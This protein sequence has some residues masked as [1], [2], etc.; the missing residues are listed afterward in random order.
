MMSVKKAAIGCTMRI[1]ERVVRVSGGRLNVPVASSVRRAESYASVSAF[2]KN[3]IC[4]R[5]IISL[6][7][8]AILR[9]RGR[10]E[11]K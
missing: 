2:N 11:L 10:D 4:G 9:S 5:C 7:S 1:E 3:D 6:E 8:V